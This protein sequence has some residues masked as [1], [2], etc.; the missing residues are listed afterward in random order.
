MGIGKGDHIA[1]WSTNYPQWV[2]TQIAASKIGAVLVTVNTAY[3]RFELEYLLRQSD[4]STLITMQ[5]LKDSNYIEHILGICP[6]L[7]GCK[8]GQLESEALPCL[9]RVIYLDEKRLT[10]CSTGKSFTISPPG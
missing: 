9:K 2:V 10:A 5:G 8:P 7:S 4:S 6:E 3:K 1:I